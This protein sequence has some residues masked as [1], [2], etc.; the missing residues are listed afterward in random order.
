MFLN[1]KR[2]FKELPIAFGIIIYAFYINWLS[3]NIGIMPIDTFGFLDTGFSI[4]KNRLPI[5]DFWIFTG[6]LVDYMESFFLLVFGNKW[7]SHLIHAS[8]MNIIASL[9]VYFFLI[10]IKLDKK[11]S[12]FYTISFATLCYP[13]SGTPF[14][15]IHSY[16]FSLIAILTLISA[17]QNKKNITWFL[18]PIISFL[19]FLSMQTPAAYIII[20]IIFFSFHYFLIEKNLSNLKYFLYGFSLC[21]V[22]F[23]VFLILTKTPI[24]NFIYQYI[25]FPLTIGEGR[26]VSSEMAYVSLIDQLNFK[27]IFGEFKFIHFFLI[28]LILITVKNFKKKNKDINILNLVFIFATI[29]F[30]FNQLLTANQ[31][32]IFSL[33]P[34]LAAILH[35][36]FIKFKLSPKICFLILFIVLFATVKFHHRYNIDRKFHDLEAVDK[37]KAMDA[38]LIHKN[39][40]GLKWI[41]KYNQ[42][43]QVEINTI[44]NAIQKID[45]DDREKILIT[46][47]QFISTILNKNL[48]ILNRWYLW[49][50]NTHP[51]ENHKYFEFYKKMVNNNLINNKIKVIYLLGQENEILFDDV[52]NYFTDICFKSETLEK[53]KFSSHEIIDCKN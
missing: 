30:I 17:I 13:V 1:N 36:N 43:P 29:A 9:S 49:D 28:P 12:L 21:V 7:S 10:N 20:L 11:Y 19:S 53:N 2:I 3:G 37:S 25:L 34:L 22:F 32:Y 44:K 16:I 39:L 51:T 33:V 18:I 23:S 47:Y 15:Y 52:N 40:K 41:S 42:N 48:N 5:R 27:R 35:I 45:N 6:L 24:E 31:I 38:Q 14:A 26:L 46:H 50:N 8:F 4:L